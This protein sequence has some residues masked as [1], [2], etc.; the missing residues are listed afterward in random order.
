MKKSKRRLVIVYT[1]LIIFYAFLLLPI[2]WLV[3]SS[4]RNTDSIQAGRLVPY[5]SELTVM[6]YVEAFRIANLTTFLINS[7]VIAIS[8]MLVVVFIASRHGLGAA[9][10]EDTVGPARAPLEQRASARGPPRPL[11]KGLDLG[12]QRRGRV[13]V[14]ERRPVPVPGRAAISTYWSS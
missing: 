12:R 13:L 1:G 3:L 8:V 2:V 11:G 6:N 10:P 5:P 9:A 4:F 14:G 7:F